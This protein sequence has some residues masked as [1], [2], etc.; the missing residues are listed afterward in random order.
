[1]DN[2]DSVL[3]YADLLLKLSQKINSIPGQVKAY[4]NF[5]VA[6]SR[7]FKFDKALSY[8]L[9][10]RDI[11]EKNNTGGISP[12]L[13]Q[14]GYIYLRLNRK[15][16]AYKYF[17]QQQSIAILEKNYKSYLG[18]IVN[19]ADYYNTRN[20]LDSS[21]D[22]LNKGLNIARKY[23]FHDNEVIILDNIANAYYAKAIENND[24]ALFK[25]VQL[26][27]DTAL[28]LHYKDKDSS[29]IF[30]IYG[31]LGSLNKDLGNYA[32]AEKYYDQYISY[33]QRTKDIMNLKIALDEVSL[34]YAVQGKF[35]QAYSSRLMYD[36]I[37]KLYVD[38]EAHLQVV[39]LNTKYETEK[40]EEQNALL[41]KKNDLS[42]KTIN[43]QKT[44]NAF[45]IISLI[46]SILFGIFMFRIYRQKKNAHILI[47]KQKEEVEQKQVE[48]EFQKGVIEEKQ[49][50]IVDSINYARRIQYALLPADKILCA[51]LS[52]HFILFK[53]KD[54]VSGDFYWV[55][56]HHDNFYLAVCDS[57][58]HGVP[59]AF[60]SLL[61]TGFLSEAVKEKHILDPNEILNYVRE[62]LIENISGDG[63]QDGMDC[64]LLRINKKE[65]IVT[66]SA[67]NNAPILIRDNKMIELPKD[68]MPVGKGEKLTTFTLHQIKELNQNDTLY[69]YTDGYADQFGGPEIKK[70]KSRRLNELLL[71]ISDKPMA[72]QE[73]ILNTEFIEWKG[74]LEQ[75]DDVCV[76]G[77]KI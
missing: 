42:I 24:R 25:M 31:L 4:T 56:E 28:V 21:L 48:I 61:N 49:T 77:I 15:E 65:K 5:G 58:G 12:L 13:G 51:N 7:L 47:S 62:R 11:V 50:E 69:L 6:Y 40:K 52:E 36:S 64:I 35:R 2:A 75:I 20:E 34:L 22:V 23:N 33:S 29:A 72:S 60:M 71:S 9:K 39:E 63:A 44:I 54:I 17:K 26:Y 59:G 8:Y 46:L 10:A 32:K 18:C 41:I 19:L 70:Y 57:T 37:N 68:K 27:T 45:I 55:A 76:I 1:M 67:A 14:I 66:Y 38:E 16:D 53:P 43:Q 73:N 3:K 74:P 30:Y